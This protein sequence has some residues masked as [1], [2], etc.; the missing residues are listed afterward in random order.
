MNTIYYS[1]L[2]I[3]NSHSQTIFN[4]VRFIFTRIFG[5]FGNLPDNIPI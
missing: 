3:I 2:I 4:I 5:I 1:V